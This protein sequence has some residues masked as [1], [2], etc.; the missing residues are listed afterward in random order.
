MIR[1]SAANTGAVLSGLGQICSA[2]A[3][4]AGERRSRMAGRV[5][6]ILQTAFVFLFRLFNLAQ[7]LQVITGRFC[8]KLCA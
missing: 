2:A 7:V 4:G 6:L 8:A 3:G 5:G 1:R